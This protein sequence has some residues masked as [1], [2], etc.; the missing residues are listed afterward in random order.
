MNTAN[1]SYTRNH[2][3][4]LLALVREGKTVLILDRNQP[5]ARLEPAM[6]SETEVPEWKSSLVRRGILHPARRQL[7]PKT[8]CAMPE[9]RPVNGGDILKALLANRDEDR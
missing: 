6:N 8:F 1:V 5:V 2:F 9:V 4:R 7:N 3:S